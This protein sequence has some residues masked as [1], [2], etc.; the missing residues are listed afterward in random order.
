VAQ[1][2]GG[3]RPH[4][5]GQLAFVGGPRVRPTGGGRGGTASACRRSRANP[6]RGAPC[7]RAGG[8]GRTSVPS[9]R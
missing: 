9:T 6:P 7:G 3:M 8:T 1:R 5:G 4:P 2:I